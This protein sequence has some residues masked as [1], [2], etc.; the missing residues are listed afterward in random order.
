M[1]RQAPA[2]GR[3]LVTGG[4]GFIGCALSTRGGG[5]REVVDSLHPQVHASGER[6]AALHKAA[7]ASWSWPTSSNP[8]R[9]TRCWRGCGPTGRPPRGRDRD[10]AV[11]HRGT[12][13]SSV[14]VVGTTQLLD[15]L[16]RPGRCRTAS[17]SPAAAR[18]T[19]RARGGVLTSRTSSPALARTR[20]SRRGSGTSR[21]GAP[22]RLRARDQAHSA[23]VYGATKLAQENILDAWGGIDDVPASVF[24]LQNVY[25]P[26]PVPDQPV[27]RHRLAFVQMARDGRSIPVYEDGEIAR[28]FV[29]IDDVV[30]AR[31]P[32]WRRRRPRPSGRSTWARRAHHDPR[33]GDDRGAVPPRPGASRDRSVPG[34][35]RPPRRL[36]RPAHGRR[37]RMEASVVA[38]RRGGRPPGLDRGTADLSS[39]PGGQAFIAAEG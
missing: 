38:D 2:L 9:G 13:H 19:A 23:S 35:R 34:R 4:A 21:V 26:G 20:S 39:R 27:H 14:N 33:P 1:T 16:T 28:D 31:S 7:R 8:R 11:S 30:S 10:R 18:C 25:G 6:P 5:A 37:A 3:V 12:R 17:C 22:A 15:G 32:L 36:R 24:R 29:L